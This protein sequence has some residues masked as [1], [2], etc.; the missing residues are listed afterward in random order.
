MPQGCVLCFS[1]AAFLQVCRARLYALLKQQEDQCLFNTKAW[2]TR[3][4]TN[5]D[6][7][8]E[9]GTFRY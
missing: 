3:E 7:L 4:A 9:A 1:A 2:V 5:Q 8:Q 6:A